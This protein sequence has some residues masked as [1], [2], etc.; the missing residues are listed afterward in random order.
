VAKHR[1][2]PTGTLH[3]RFREKVARFEDLLV[4]EPEDWP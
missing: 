3:L 2:G 4:Q 1:N